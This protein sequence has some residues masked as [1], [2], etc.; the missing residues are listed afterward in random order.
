MSFLRTKIKYRW[1]W[2]KNPVRISSKCSWK[3]HQKD[4]ISFDRTWGEFKA[5]CLNNTRQLQ[6]NLFLYAQLNFA[7]HSH[8]FLCYVFMLWMIFFLCTFSVNK[9]NLRDLHGNLS[10]FVFQVIISGKQIL[11][12]LSLIQRDSLIEKQNKC[13]CDLLQ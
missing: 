2:D 4:R 11:R 8:S 9:A 3:N 12:Y 10:F 1:L 7:W 5:F 13:T 6:W